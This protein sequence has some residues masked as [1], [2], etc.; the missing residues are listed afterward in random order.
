MLPPILATIT[1]T[2]M[3]ATRSQTQTGTFISVP[4]EL[5]G[6]L[7]T[8]HTPYRVGNL[9]L[10]ESHHVLTDRE[11]QVHRRFPIRG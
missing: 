11:P 4:P 6:R 7:V 9:V 5:M 1:S 10:R 8:F 2:R 3:T